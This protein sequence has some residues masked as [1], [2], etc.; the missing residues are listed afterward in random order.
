LPLAASLSPEDAM[1]WLIIIDKVRLLSENYDSQ[2]E[3][4]EDQLHLVDTDSDENPLRL[5]K[6]CLNF[7][8]L[9]LVEQT[10]VWRS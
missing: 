4:P 3:V 6:S 2:P 5:Y 1:Q 10:V 7:R 8:L 9:E